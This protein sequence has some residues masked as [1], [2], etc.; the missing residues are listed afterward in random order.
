MTEDDDFLDEDDPNE[1]DAQPDEDDSP[2]DD[3]DVSAW[4][5]PPASSNNNALEWLAA[6]GI[7][8]AAAIWYF[9]PT[10][11]VNTPQECVDS[12][13]AAVRHAYCPMPVKERLL[14][15]L[16]AIE[17]R[18]QGG[19]KMSAARWQRH[20]SVMKDII[21]RGIIPDSV[22]LLERELQKVEND[23]DEK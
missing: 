13:T 1:G 18:I 22:P 21:R 14:N 17:A 15:R 10:P 4:M 6:I 19:E 5:T 3:V 12:W 9:W 2:D 8:V 11:H 23:L 7:I 16:D 20:D